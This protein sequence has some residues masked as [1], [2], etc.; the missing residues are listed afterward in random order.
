MQERSKTGDSLTSSAQ[1]AEL[2]ESIHTAKLLRESN[3]TL[4]DENEANL[5]KVTT[6]DTQLHQVQGELNPLK[7]HVVT[8]QAEVESKQH[9]IRLLE[10]DNERWKTRNQT[11]LAKY[12]RIDPEELQVLK[13]EVDKVQAALTASQAERDDLAAKLTEQTNLVRPPA[14]PSLPPRHVFLHDLSC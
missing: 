2:L 7:E 14:S 5:R 4:R 8:L 6:L 1:H 9:Q 12:E 10:E 3:Q 13:T 11:I